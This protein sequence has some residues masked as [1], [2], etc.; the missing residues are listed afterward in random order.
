LTISR[1][2]QIHLFL[3]AFT[4]RGVG[5]DGF[6]DPGVKQ[7]RADVFNHEI[8]KEFGV[9]LFQFEVEVVGAVALQF[10]VASRVRCG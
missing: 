5:A 4:V 1:S 7:R 3:N 2:F 9:E 10:R 6:V 8:D